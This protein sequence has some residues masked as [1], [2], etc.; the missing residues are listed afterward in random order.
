MWWSVLM[1]SV[2]RVLSFHS[3]HNREIQTLRSGVTMVSE[4]RARS[5]EKNCCQF[6]KHLPFISLLLKRQRHKAS[7]TT[8]RRQGF[9]ETGDKTLSKSCAFFC[10]LEEVKARSSS[11]EPE[12]CTTFCSI[13]K[14]HDRCITVVC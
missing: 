6:T 5:P 2:G 4:D 11:A 14:Q 8:D 3:I 1:L 9:R 7:A 10:V 12:S 13:W